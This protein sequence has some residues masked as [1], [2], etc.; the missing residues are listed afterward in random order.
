MANIKSKKVTR[1]QKVDLDWINKLH[2]DQDWEQLEPRIK[3]LQVKR[4]F[5]YFDRYILGHTGEK[6]SRIYQLKGAAPLIYLQ[7]EKLQREIESWMRKEGSFS[8]EEIVCW[9]IPRFEWK[10]ERITPEQEIVLEEWREKYKILDRTDWTEGIT[11]GEQERKKLDKYRQV[12]ILQPRQTGKSEVV[13]RVNAYIITTVHNFDSAVFAPTE[14]QAKDFIFQRTRDYIEENPFYKGRFKTLNALDMTLSPAPLASGSSFVAGSASPGANI[15]GDSLDW[16]IIDESQDVTDFKIRKSIK[17]MMAAKKGSMIKIGT[18]NTVKGHFWESTTKKGSRFWHQVIIYP[19]VC[20]ATNEWWRE[21]IENVIEEDGRWSDTVRMSVFL[22]WLLSL[23]MFMTEEQWDSMQREDLNWVHYDKTGLQFAAVDVAK[24]RDETVVM[25]GKIDPT[26]VIAGRHPVRILNIKT[27][28]GIDYD[29]Q[30]E[31]IK[32]W[33]DQNYRIAA[34]GVDDTGGR[35]GLADR[36]AKTSMRVDAFTYTR[37]GKSEW[38]TNLQTM[39]NAHYTAYKEGRTYDLLIEIPGS[40]EAQKEKIWRDFCQQMLDLQ[41]EFKD[42][43]MVVHHPAIEGARDDYPDT[44]MMLAWM[45]SRVMTSIDE[46]L[47]AVEEI[48]ETR[49]DKLDWNE[50]IDGQQ[51]NAQRTE[52][53][54]RRAAEGDDELS[55]IMRS[56]TDLDSIF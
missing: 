52:R 7:R 24:S 1:K 6:V 54:S 47:E 40:E 29:S 49:M 42:K 18:V 43:Y 27:L 22:E 56:S 11:I 26:R 15:E 4:D 23:G 36:F 55:E 8:E 10:E 35:G 50:D 28:P 39:V 37:P 44:L 32:S 41:R 30:Y 13:V 5:R 19:D 12:A 2:P 21:F 46:M 31:E 3:K 14:D 20:A 45:A 38:Y 48:T 53:R 17:F 16:A 33:L 9:S 25:V 34:I 51:R